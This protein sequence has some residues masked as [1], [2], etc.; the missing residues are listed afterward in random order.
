MRPRYLY[1]ALLAACWLI[2]VVTEAA[3]LRGKILNP[4]RQPIDHAK[5]VIEGN[6]IGQARVAFSKQNGEFYFW[7]LP[8]GN[9]SITVSYKDAVINRGIRI[10]DGEN[11]PEIIVGGK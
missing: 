5:V 2:P 3:E 4:Q 11:T 7:G 8:P 10:S 6:I 9:Y 1:C